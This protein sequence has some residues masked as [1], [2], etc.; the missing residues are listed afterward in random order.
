[1]AIKAFEIDYGSNCPKAVAKI[2]IA[3]GGVSEGGH[4]ASLTA[5]TAGDAHL[6]G[7]VGDHVGVSSAVGAVVANCPRSDFSFPAGVTR[8]RPGSSRLRRPRS[9][10][11]STGSTTTPSLR[12]RPARVIASTLARRRPDPARR[13]RCGFNHQ[14]SRVLHEALSAVGAQSIYVVIAGAGHD[15][16]EF[17]APA[18]TA[19]V[20]G[21]LAEKLG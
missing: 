2:V 18:I 5:L 20:A 11:G 10:S 8:S 6:E 16:P 19:T 17:V 21:F 1:M 15:G 9:C 4:L 12:D 7:D 14:E 13:S 3:M